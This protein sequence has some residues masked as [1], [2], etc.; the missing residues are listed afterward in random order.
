M[1]NDMFGWA[2]LRAESP[3]RALAAARLVLPTVGARG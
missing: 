3:F 2:W 1:L